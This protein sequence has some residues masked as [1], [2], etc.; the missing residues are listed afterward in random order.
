MN[1]L[2]SPERPLW[3]RFVDFP[4][5]A[6]VVAIAFYLM[7]VRLGFYLGQFVSAGQPATAIIQAA[8]TL[9]LTLV[10]YKLAIT[11]LGKR[12]RDDLRT[13]GAV[14]DLVRGL[15]T[16]AALF[17]AVVGV[18]A[19]FGVYR[20]TGRGTVSEILVP[21]IATSIMPG[22]M[23]EIF[24]RGILFRWIE[25]FAGSWAALIVTSALFGI[26]HILNPGATWFSSFAI[27]I[28]A[29]LL[30]GSVYMLTRSLWMPIGLHAAWNFIQGPVFGVPVSGG[31]PNGLLH[32]ALEG[33]TLLTGGAFGL[34]ASLICLTLATTAGLW[35]LWLALNRG[36]VVRP[37]WSRRRPT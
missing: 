36:A 12:P 33:P 21:V 5:V 8:V 2:A 9:T 26:A 17:S 30:L 23:E 4:L 20:V 25:E 37:M 3:N 13:A 24:F 14:P 29:G 31:P 35:F 11:R 10:T 34:E 7:A 6:M 28:E 27:A 22:F 32:S 15:A 1:D 16:G 19:A 18:A